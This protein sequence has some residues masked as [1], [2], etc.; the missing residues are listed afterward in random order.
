MAMFHRPT[1]ASLTA[2]IL[3]ALSAWSCQLPSWTYPS[4]VV[5]LSNSPLHLVIDNEAPA[6]DYFVLAD[7]QAKRWYTRDGLFRLNA[8]REVVHEA[9]GMALY[10]LITIPKDAIEI[11]VGEDGRVLVR[12]VAE[13]EVHVEVGHILIARF[14]NPAGLAPLSPTLFQPQGASGPAVLGQPA[15]RGLGKLRSG[16][17]ELP[18]FVMP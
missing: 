6:L 3:A 1:V 9:T 5:A 18:A 7:A 16:V 12:R 13:P 10:P 8:A 4:T 14:P 2:S 15:T 11:F 17:Q